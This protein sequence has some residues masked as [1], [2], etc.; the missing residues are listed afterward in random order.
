MKKSNIAGIAVAWFRADEWHELKTLCPD[1]QNTYEE[2]LRNAEAGIDALGPVKNQVEKV[3]L[4]TDQLRNWKRATG[5]K[6]DSKVRAR[7]ATIALQKRH[8]TRH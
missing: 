6:I 5:R 7:L 1:L 8:G 4:T 2:W 3:I